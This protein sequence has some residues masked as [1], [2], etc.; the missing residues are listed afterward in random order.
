[1]KQQTHLN[2]AQ[3]EKLK[4]FLLVFPIVVFALMTI[5]FWALGG[6]KSE[7]GQPYAAKGINTELPSA[8]FKDEKAEDKLSLYDQADKDSAL[9]K[10]H[11]NNPVFGGGGNTSGSPVITGPNN[12][13]ANTAQINQK[14]AQ[15]RQQINTAP[16]V[17]A[18]NTL[19]K[20][21]AA[22]PAV[23][24]ADVDRLEKL[25][26]DMKSQNADDPEMKQL[27]G[28]VDKIIQIQH[29]EMVTAQIKQQVKKEPDSLFKAIPA[30]IDGNQ[31][32][33]QGGIVK[34]R[35]ADSV[36]LN[37]IKV[38]KG[39]TLFGNCTITNQRL[40]LN[41]KTI[42]LGNSII[43]V[44]LTV[45]SQDGIPGIDAPEAELGQAAGNGTNDAL[46]SMEFLPMDQ[47]LSTQAASAGIN[48]AKG[49][50]GKKVKKIRVKLKG[51]QQI[52]L[53]DNTKKN[54]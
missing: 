4:K 22:S 20:T 31:K 35:L 49:L 13:D 27:A 51:G 15:I 30:V 19:T 43:P 21:P 18:P 46:S 26:K 10:S 41:I 11:A 40:L 37:S 45:F 52:L 23:N 28:M 2:T 9:A 5:T 3:R 33:L 32:V 8:Q 29:P 34:L 38:P 16:E 53:R 17:T 54:H 36:T 6:G 25:M 1:M 44:D 12:A 47:T 42:R 24:S 7:A 14:L 39:F 48:A 50:I